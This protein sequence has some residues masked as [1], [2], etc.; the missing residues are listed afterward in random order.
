MKNFAIILIVALLSLPFL[1]NAQQAN[2]LYYMDRV[3]QSQTVNISEIPENKVQVGGL[4]VP[5]IGQLP[6]AFYFNYGKFNITA[7]NLYNITKEF[8]AR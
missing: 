4:I 6:P 1:S 3:F 2:T 7:R 5:I 8:I